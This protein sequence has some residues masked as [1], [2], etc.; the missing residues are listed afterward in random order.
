MRIGDPLFP[1]PPIDDIPHQQFFL[2]CMSKTKAHS[3]DNTDGHS[4]FIDSLLCTDI[5]LH[6][7]SSLFALNEFLI[8]FY[9]GNHQKSKEIRPLI[10]LPEGG[11]RSEGGFDFEVKGIRVFVLIQTH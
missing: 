7:R 2:K 10:P 11:G 6:R 9:H 5:T 1:K 8:H 4:L 3:A